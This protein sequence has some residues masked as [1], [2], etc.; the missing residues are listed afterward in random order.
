M[1][2]LIEYLPPDLQEV[3]DFQALTE[4]EVP[5]IDAATSATDLMLDNQFASTASIQ[6]VRR[7][8]SILRIQ[9]NPAVEDLDFRRKRIINRLSTKAPFTVRWL[10]GQLNRLVGAGMTVVSVDHNE[11]TLYVTTNIENANLFREVQHTVE[12]VKP[13][14]LIYKQNTSLKHRI[15]IKHTTKARTI[16]WNYKLDGSWKLG[17]KPFAT[18]GPEVTL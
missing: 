14:N 5:E 17:E 3:E 13:A 18:L 12:V 1:N 10:Q 4:A 16:G 9:A 15:G 8:E 11:Y 6:A 2:R 7:F